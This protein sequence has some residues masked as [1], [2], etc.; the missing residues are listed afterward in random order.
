MQDRFKLPELLAPAGSF[1]HLKA[2]IKAGADAVY[3]GGQRFGARAYA[4]NL[5]DEE[6]ADAL[7]YAHFYGRRLY[8]T[9]NTLMKEDEINHILYGFLQ[10]YY[11][12]GLDGVIVQ[13]LGTASFIRKNFPDMEVHG[14][15]Q[16]TITHPAGAMAAGKMGMTRVVP[17]REL[18]LEELTLIK[19][20]SGLELEVFVHGA[21]CYCYSGQCLLSSFYGGRSGNRGRCAQPCRLPYKNAAGQEACF[22][23]LR[24]LCSLEYLPELVERGF[25][26]LKIEGRMKN[27]EYVAGV[28]SIY[29]KYLDLY[30]ELKTQGHPEHFR[31]EEEDLNTLEELYCR[32][33]FTGG[34]WNRHNGASMM[35]LH[36]QKN[37]GRQIGEILKVSRH[38]VRIRLFDTL[39]PRDLLV[40]PR[41]KDQELVLTVP[42]EPGS[43][44]VADLNIADSRGLKASMPVYRRRNS[45]L[46]EKIQKE[47]IHKRMTL[48]AEGKVEI[49]RGRPTRVT[50]SSGGV[51]V[52]LEGAEAESAK[53]KAISEADVSKQFHKT[54]ETPFEMKELSVILEDN[55]FIPL[56]V[57]KGLRQEAFLLLEKKMGSRYDRDKRKELPVR[58]GTGTGNVTVKED[59]VPAPGKTA[60]IYDRKVLNE[61][62]SLDYYTGICLPAD[63]WKEEELGDL[64]RRIRES[65]K[66]ALLSLPSVMRSGRGSFEDICTSL[67]WDGIY[68]HNINEAFWLKKLTGFKG[69]RIAGASFYQWNRE[70][71]EVSRRITGISRSQLSPELKTDEYRGIEDPGL[72]RELLVYGRIPLMVTAQCQKKAAGKCDHQSENLWLED[73]QGRKLPVSTHCDYCYNKIW[74]HQPIDRVGSD[75]HDLLNGRTD[76]VF[77]FYLAGQGIVE[78]VMEKCLIWEEGQFRSL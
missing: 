51:S 71:L 48:P 68:V 15:T 57:L 25:D 29:R 64:N 21:L 75:I 34:Y 42:K 14:S 74:S 62:L 20:E 73:R 26:S 30:K 50:L 52:S 32:G 22:L 16:M 60:F 41:G 69:E 56:S 55:C 2:A 70:S 4:R 19:K 39:Q 12:A 23:S 49:R 5:A 9:V 24:D 27:V 38:K 43:G 7:H 76:L 33:G 37:L 1:E 59:L 78:S 72:C 35:A 11:E 58:S 36:T 63:V 61:C 77:D 53:K 54:G 65:G 31:V 40:I 44:K 66:R 8:L 17:A 10:P 6:L 3:M 45:L 46:A 13:D 67:F 18:S 47:I 28:T